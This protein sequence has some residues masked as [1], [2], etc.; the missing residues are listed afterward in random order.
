MVTTQMIKVHYG[1]YNCIEKRI[2]DTKQ[3]NDIMFITQQISVSLP[4][5]Y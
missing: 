4:T 5:G 1:L 2:S 3:E